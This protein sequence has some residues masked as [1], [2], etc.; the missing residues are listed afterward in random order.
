MN[1]REKLDEIESYVN[2]ALEEAKE[3]GKELE[4]LSSENNLLEL[5]SQLSTIDSMVNSL[6]EAS[7]KL[8]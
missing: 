2:S 3:L 8:Y 4:T 5:S 6:E 1:V 7:K